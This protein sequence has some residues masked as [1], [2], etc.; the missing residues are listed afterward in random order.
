M[1]DLTREF[2]EN[3]LRLEKCII[4]SLAINDYPC[5]DLQ[6]FIDDGDIFD[7]IGIFKGEYPNVVDYINGLP[8]DC[9]P[10][11][12]YIVEMLGETTKSNFLANVAMP[13]RYYGRDGRSYACSWSHY[14]SKW[15]LASDVD[16]IIAMAIEWANSVYLSKGQTK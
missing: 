15:I 8:N 7:N 6:E 9:E 16:S 11:V 4:L 3:G 1:A 5:D 13:V 12:E 10:D 2:F 14:Q